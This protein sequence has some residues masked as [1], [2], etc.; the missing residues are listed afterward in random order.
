MPLRLP[1]RA[2][3][4]P[5]LP[6][7]PRP[8]MRTRG[9]HTKP[10]TQGQRVRAGVAGAI[11]LGL[12]GSYF[13][14]TTPHPHKDAFHT[15]LDP[16]PTGSG[17]VQHDLPAALREIQAALQE[18]QITLDSMETDMH[19]SSPWSYH[20]TH[21]HAAVV[22]PQS[23]EDVV[24]V[25]QA[26]SRFNVPIVPFGGGTSLEGHTSGTNP[27]SDGRSSISLDFSRMKAILRL[28]EVDGDVTVQPG[29][30][31]E[32]LNEELAR[33][34]TGLFF[35]IDPGPTASIGGMAATG[36]SGT[37]AVRYGTMKGDH[38]LNVTV[39]LPSGEVVTTR[40]RAR[41]SSVGPDLTKLFLGSEATLGVIVDITLR[42]VPVLPNAVVV[43]T[44]PSVDDAV[45]ATGAVLKAGL[46]P[47]CVELMNGPMIGAVNRAAAEDPATPHMDGGEVPTIFLKLQGASAKHITADWEVVEPILKQYGSEHIQYGDDQKEID[48][49]WKARK[50]GLWS[51]M[52]YPETPEPE[53]EDA[54]DKL[55]PWRA[56]VTDVCV[57][58]GQLPALVK[59]IE[60]DISEQKLYGPILG[61]VG[62][63][64]VH[65]LLIYREKDAA[66]LERVKEVVH[67]M[68]HHAQDLDGTATGEHGVGVG[69]KSFLD[70]ELGQGTVSIY[71]NIMNQLDPNN[72]MNPGK[73]VDSDAALQNIELD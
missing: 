32:D 2:R 46:Q 22:Y 33:R 53:A 13:I 63:G 6:A 69:K 7:P 1:V 54:E 65:A 12:V 57:P 64:N 50:V 48:R 11:A 3:A 18:D 39:V 25:V 37:N 21:P 20:K 15:E 27:K 28:S 23:T 52:S 35:P 66:T 56:W 73:L 67:R 59:R 14:P 38:V 71:R 19:G 43:A 10:L 44:F 17:P 62:D 58:V 30:G 8:A 49:L 16:K 61:H 42:L 24:A 9:L 70:A 51:A 26:C 55:G 34:E 72:I 41:K 36:C 40:S 45:A 31:W 68:I 29:I 47:Q 4:L 5:R 60:G